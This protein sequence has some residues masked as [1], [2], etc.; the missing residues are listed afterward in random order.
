MKNVCEGDG[1]WVL[2]LM[3]LFWLKFCYG[4]P[5]MFD[6]FFVGLIE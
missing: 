6:L 4:A 2:V 1:E 5:L 3:Y